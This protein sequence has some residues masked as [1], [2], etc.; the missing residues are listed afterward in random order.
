MD[1][2]RHLGQC[3]LVSCRRRHAHLVGRGISSK[4][5]ECA[6]EQHAD[7]NS[8][9][10]LGR[11]PAVRAELSAIIRTKSFGMNDILRSHLHKDI[12]HLES[13]LHDAPMQSREPLSRPVA[14]RKHCLSSS[15]KFAVGMEYSVTVGPSGSP[16]KTV[17]MWWDPLCNQNQLSI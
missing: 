1:S 15:H 12:L 8:D 17:D 2:G 9:A 7:A 3:L 4:Q 6:P 10:R 5:S 14:W 16:E 13:H 11:E